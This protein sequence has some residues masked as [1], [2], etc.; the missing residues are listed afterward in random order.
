[1]ASLP[2]EDPG[3]LLII[4]PGMSMEVADLHTRGFIDSVRQRCRG[5][6]IVTVD[7]GRESYLDGSVVSRM[8]DAIAEAHRFAPGRLWLAGISL[9]CQAILRCA[10]TQPDLAE[11]LILLTP[12]LA[13]SGL[14]ADVG[15]AGGLRAWSVLN[16]GRREPEHALLT[17]LA[18][19]PP[20]AMPRFL[21][22]RARADRFVATANLLAD[23]LP[24]AQVTTVPGGHDWT[25]WSA[26]WSLILDRQP[27]RPQAT[28][29][30]GSGMN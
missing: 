28:T 24:A 4:V 29:L 13:S 5:V 2:N 11:G 23:L 8:T 18:T 3:V 1:M 17:W 7:P 16:I 15:R 10:Q 9:G 19:A 30:C 21:L 22:G 12:Y 27:F 14:I 25:S 26:L 20:A 6:S